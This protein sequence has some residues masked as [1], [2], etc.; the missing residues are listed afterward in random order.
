MELGRTMLVLIPKVNADTWGIGMLEV[1]W[2]VAE[3][4]IKNRINSVVQFHDVLERFWHRQGEM[5]RYYGA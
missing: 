4:A 5:D 1:V 3:A 2:N